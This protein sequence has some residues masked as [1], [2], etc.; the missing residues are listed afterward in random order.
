MTLFGSTCVTPLIS[1]LCCS[2]QRLQMLQ[3]I[4][5]DPN[6]A[7]RRI[8]RQPSSAEAALRP[9]IAWF[10]VLPFWAWCMIWIRASHQCFEA[11]SQVLGSIPMMDGFI[12][13]YF[14][15]DRAD[16]ALTSGL[17][18]FQFASASACRMARTKGAIRSVLRR[19]PLQNPTM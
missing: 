2:M 16:L 13:S 1:T 9:K 10:E 15:L 8:T 5:P 14:P 6:S 11:C 12:C 18:R 19:R 3:C 7:W 4:G 17:L